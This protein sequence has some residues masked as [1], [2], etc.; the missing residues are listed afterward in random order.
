MKWSPGLLFSIVCLVIFIK[1]YD[2]FYGGRPSDQFSFQQ[3]FLLLTM[4][5]VFVLLYILLN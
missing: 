1:G 4:F 2:A 3:V 5:S